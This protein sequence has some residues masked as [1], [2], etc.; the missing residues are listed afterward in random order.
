MKLHRAITL[1]VMIVASLLLLVVS[2]AFGAASL[3]P[4]SLT[5]LLVV[6]VAA[7]IAGIAFSWK[8]YFPRRP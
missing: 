4:G 1:V 8:R 7:A 3:G 2:V 6:V 5:A